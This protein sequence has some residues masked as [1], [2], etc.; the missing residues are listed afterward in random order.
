MHIRKLLDWRKLLIYSH[1]W[2]GIVITI[3]FLV[4]TLSGVV[5]MYYG[6]PHYTA[7]DRLA[8]L[9]PLD[10]STATLS[11]EEALQKVPGTAFRLRIS[12]QDNRPAYHINTGELDFPFSQ[13][14]ISPLSSH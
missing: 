9:P 10:L 4:W 7:G 2:L 8:H 1:R 6:I 14:V 3:M 12:M 5:L 13:C 11:P